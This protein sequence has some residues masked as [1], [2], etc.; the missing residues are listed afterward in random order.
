ME[1]AKQNPCLTCKSLRKEISLTPGEVIYSGT[2]WQVEHAYPTSVRGWLVC[3]LKRH[4]SALHELTKEEM[5]ECA[6]IHHACVSALRKETGCEKEYSACFAEGAG[7]NHVHFHIIARPKDL[8]ED[9]RGPHIFTLLG[10]KMESPVPEEEIASLCKTLKREVE[11]FF[12]DTN[13]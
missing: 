4:A 13:T 2:F 9:A 3:I 5:R 1:N 6:E 12:V 7:F 10:K 11:S 8:P